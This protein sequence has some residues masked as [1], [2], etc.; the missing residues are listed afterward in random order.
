MDTPL[1]TGAG[2][3][4][5]A[6]IGPLL[7]TCK[8]QGCHVAGGAAVANSG[9]IVRVA[10]TTPFDRCPLA[11]RS[12][13]QFLKL[14]RWLVGLKRFYYRRV[15]GMDLHP[16]CVFSLSA[17]FDRTNPRGIHVGEWSY[18][19][20]DAA[21]LSHDMTRGARDHTRIGRCCFIGARSIILPG[22]TIGDGSIVAAGS[23]VTRDV[24]PATIVAGNPAKVIR[25][26]I[27]VGRFGRLAGA[28][29]HQAQQMAK[30]QF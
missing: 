22:V 15:W 28:D 23:V 27:K 21:I 8:L 24:E 20:F 7:R 16:T 12:L 29:I 4:C 6:Q 5:S 17:R 3:G 11:I 1:Q 9:E 13:N 26:G 25:T 2:E 30:H 19:A 10:E 18:I 14:Q